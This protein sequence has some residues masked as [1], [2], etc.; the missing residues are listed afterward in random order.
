MKKT[1]KGYSI[2]YMCAYDFAKTL[3]VPRGESS[4]TGIPAC[5]IKWISLVSLGLCP[6][7]TALVKSETKL[8]RIQLSHV[9]VDP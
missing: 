3:D 5:S 6:R 9:M 8:R 4:G 1:Y 2:E 7:F